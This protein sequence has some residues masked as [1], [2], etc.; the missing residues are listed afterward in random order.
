MN[1]LALKQQS[2]PRDKS[3]ILFVVLSMLWLP[4]AI[5][6]DESASLVDRLLECRA[7][8]DQQL[9]LR[10]FDNATELLD[11]SSDVQVSTEQVVETEGQVENNQISLEQQRLAEERERLERQQRELEQRERELATLT[12][13]ARPII[14]PTEADLEAAFG[15]DNIPNYDKPL[16]SERTRQI[17]TRIVDLAQESTGK[18]IMTMANGQVWIQTQPEFYPLDLADGPVDVVLFRGLLGAYYLRK[19]DENVRLRVRRIN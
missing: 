7:I 11:T 3:S 19:Q 14:A 10:C 9:R 4:V 12:E 6:A 13:R 5:Q 16:P 2:H 1:T 17:E 18:W 8:E 15:A